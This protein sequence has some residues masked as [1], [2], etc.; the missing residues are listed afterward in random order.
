MTRPTNQGPIDDPAAVELWGRV[1]S[2]FHATS[3]RVHAAM[4]EV[5]ELTE[6]E[7]QTLLNILRHPQRRVPMAQLA[8]A[9]SFS[10]GG[11]TK[12]ADKLAR[13]GLVVRVA[14]T[15]DRRVTLL[16]LTSAGVE[17]AGEL[18]A[19]AAAANR[20]HFIDVLGLERAR[21]VADAM[22]ELYRV[23]R[24]DRG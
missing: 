10:T 13:G 15:D 19:A 11:F 4:S 9:A 22:T 23:N 7:A 8:R 3:R 20:A 17:L 24:A 12:L 5:A 6:A 14:C 1:I 21:A 2:G 18:A 16:A